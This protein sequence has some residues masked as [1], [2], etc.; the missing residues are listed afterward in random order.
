MLST[1]VFV[2]KKNLAQHLAYKAG[3]INVGYITRANDFFFQLLN[4][5]YLLTSCL[6]LGTYYLLISPYLY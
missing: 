6:F 3:L 1:L 4:R 5:L 2:I